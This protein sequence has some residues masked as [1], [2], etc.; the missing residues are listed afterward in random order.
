MILVTIASGVEF[1]NGR[2]R[3]E[4]VAKKSHQLHIVLDE[5]CSRFAALDECRFKKRSESWFNCIFRANILTS[6]H[7]RWASINLSECFVVVSREPIF[8]GCPT[9][10]TI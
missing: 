2:I 4:K 5:F 1:I 6:E 7:F 9:E 10:T 8:V 3:N